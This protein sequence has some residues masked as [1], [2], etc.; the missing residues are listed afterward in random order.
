MHLTLAHLSSDKVQ[1]NLQLGNGKEVCRGSLMD[2]PKK[3]THQDYT[4]L[5]QHEKDSFLDKE[6]LVLCR[7]FLKEL[8]IARSQCLY[9]ALELE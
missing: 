9:N 6:R 5:L 1:A 3:V 2:A 8:H 4:E 7:L